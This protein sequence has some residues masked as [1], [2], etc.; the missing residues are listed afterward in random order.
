MNTLRPQGPKTGQLVG[1]SHKCKGP[2]LDAGGSFQ[3][4]WKCYSPSSMR[5]YQS[6]VRE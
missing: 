3:N 4:Y 5:L 6:A 1:A 2:E